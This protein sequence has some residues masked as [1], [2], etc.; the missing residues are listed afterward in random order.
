MRR[1]ILCVL[2]L[3]ASPAAADVVNPAE[4]ACRDRRAGDR[5]DGGGRCVPSTCTRID[6]SGGQGPRS[7]RED[8]LLCQTPPSTRVG[9]LAP[10]P[11]GILAVGVVG[12]LIA[13]AIVLAA[14]VLFAY[15]W[16]RSHGGRG[17][18]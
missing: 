11:G 7:R 14:G 12:L 5:C 17:R 16:H 9:D 15:L 18:S 3:A 10:S 6:Y 1:S 2:L 13:G 8:C 4:F